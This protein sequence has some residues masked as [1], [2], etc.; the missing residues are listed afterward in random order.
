MAERTKLDPASAGTYGGSL[1]R[2]P[3]SGA[4]PGDTLPVNSKW[5]VPM[6]VVT[7]GRNFDMNF[8][9]FYP[10]IYLSACLKTGGP[11][12]IP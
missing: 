3:A 1:P 11:I 6:P 9:D 8:F 4:E 5:R 12:T 10:I 2:V 7:H